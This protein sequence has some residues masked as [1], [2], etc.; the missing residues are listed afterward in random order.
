VSVALAIFAAVAF[1]LGN[2]MQQR[3]ALRTT[4]AGED[5]RFLLQL[6]RHP[7]WIAGGLLQIAG[8]GAQV[9]ALDKGSLLVVQVI[10]VSNFVIALP[11]GVW[12]TDQI[13][14]PH[15]LV[16]AAATVVGLVAFVVGGDPGGPG[17][18]AALLGAAAGLAFGLQAG[19]VKSLSH[20]GGG[21]GGVV[22][23][24]EL[25]A[26]AAVGVAGFVYQQRGLKVGVL[27]PTLAA[28][29]VATL[30]CSVAI[31]FAL[32][33]E[34]F[35]HGVLGVALAVPG[36]VLMVAGIVVISVGAPAP[37]VAV[38]PGATGVEAAVEGAMEIADALAP[39]PRRHGPVSDG[40]S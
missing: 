10:V 28:S 3:G 26:L 19:L 2:A 40:A 24:W 30:L 27:A 13:V 20:V 22:G 25:Y 29:N 16:G 38:A 15:H 9:V 39:K 36:L 17:P 11:L 21:L 14:R 23:S 6:F 35:G 18:A 37:A 33:S 8:F 5:P 12:L 7:V 34:S 4:A 31:G 32:F 1:A